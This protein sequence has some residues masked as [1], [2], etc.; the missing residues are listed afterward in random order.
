MCGSKP[1]VQAPPPAAPPPAPAP[2]PVMSD[3]NPELTQ[4]QRQGKINAL[5]FGAIST[6]K[7]GPRGVTGAGPDLATPAAGGTSKKKKIGE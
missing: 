5:K 6:I 7:T 3:P 2:S 1:S 4:E